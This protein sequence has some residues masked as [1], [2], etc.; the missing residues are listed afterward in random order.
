MKF[1]RL[2][3]QI[4]SIERVAPRILEFTLEPLTA[5]LSAFSPGSHILVSMNGRQREIH[6]AYSLCSDPYDTSQ[7][8]IAVRLQEQSRGGSEFLHQQVKQGDYL[9]ISP[10]VNFFMPVWNAKKHL[11][12]AGGV[13][14]TPFMSYVP[15]LIRRSADF[16]LHYLFDSK[17]GGAYLNELVQTID[18]RLHVYDSAAQ[19]RCSIV[20]VLSNQKIGTHIYV[21]GP[22][23][24]TNEVRET[25]K[26]LGWLKELIHYE[27]FSAAKA[28][29]PFRAK[30]VKSEK[31]VDVGSDESLLEALEREQIN[32]PNLCR[33]GVC[34]QCITAV[35]E[36]DIKHRD[37][38]LSASEKT[39]GRY[40][41]PCVSRAAGDQLTLNL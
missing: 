2:R 27:A 8:K 37:E 7:Y 14:I 15:E 28:G 34:G 5:V 23:R 13:G 22:D 10:P 31:S 24:L 21:C 32:V 41:M 35:I 9:D 26:K 12:I 1:E 25:A 4:S 36:G 18:A 17:S 3:V 16:E 33:G 20:D 6:N 11:L 40:I 39:K 29:S 30:L 19:Q 38:F